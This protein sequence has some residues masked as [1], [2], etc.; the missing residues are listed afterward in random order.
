MNTYTRILEQPRLAPSTPIYYILCAWCGR[1][2]YAK[3]CTESSAGKLSHGICPVCLDSVMAGY[4]K[5][6]T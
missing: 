4:K 6:E 3:P 5:D 1:V 2:L